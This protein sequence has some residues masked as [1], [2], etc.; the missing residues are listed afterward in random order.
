MSYTILY[1]R[2]YAR[3]KDGTF[4]TFTQCG[5]NNVHDVDPLTGRLR[6]SR[7]W[8]GWHFA[9]GT[10]DVK[11]SYSRKD[12]EEYV[13]HGRKAAQ[14]AAQLDLCE[15]NPAHTD[16][17]QHFG[18][19]RGVAIAGHGTTGTS[20]GAWKAFFTKAADRAVP[21]DEWV[22]LF[23]GVHLG[24]WKK[25]EGDS[26]QYVKSR[27]C[28]T[29]EDLRNAWDEARADGPGAT[30]WVIPSNG[31]LIS[32]MSTLLLATPTATGTT[33]EATF[34]DE[35]GRESGYIRTLLPLTL[36]QE[37]RE[38]LRLPRAAFKGNILRCVD[39]LRK[40]CRSLS[41]DDRL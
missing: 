10:A 32:D 27:C 3:L 31:W 29:E 34:Q 40:G 33:V 28:V 37:R 38:A 18:W 6:R 19:Y 20:F 22:R 30:I 5:D 17:R 15:D 36:T 12:I 25:T 16:W 2:L 26:E 4:L 41:Y 21:F 8:E 9:P 11:L 14:D 35:G 7:S 13:E 23:G 1:N 39:R 24:Y